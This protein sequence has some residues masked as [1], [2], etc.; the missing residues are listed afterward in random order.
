MQDDDKP[1]TCKYEYDDAQNSEDDE[2]SDGDKIISADDVPVRANKKAKKSAFDK[3]YN[4]D[5][6]SDEGN[7]MDYI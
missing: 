3:L 7:L 4:D 5:S 2:K 6:S 1:D